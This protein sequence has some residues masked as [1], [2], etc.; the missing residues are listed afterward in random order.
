MMHSVTIN[1][2][3]H[4]FRE[5]IAL[6]ELIERLELADS[7]IAVELNKSVVRKGDWADT[8]ITDSDVVE[9][10]HFVGGG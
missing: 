4:D 1:G 3:K 7:R 2:K 9:I 5:G 6:S 10:V 8:S